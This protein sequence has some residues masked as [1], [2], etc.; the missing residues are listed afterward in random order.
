MLQ[1]QTGETLN[2]I[3]NNHEKITPIAANS[4]IIK[5]VSISPKEQL[6]DWFSLYLEYQTECNSLFEYIIM[7]EENGRQ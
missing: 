5:P 3:E 7:E 2:M 4:K 1:I 6:R